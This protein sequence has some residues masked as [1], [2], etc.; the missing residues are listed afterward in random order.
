MIQRCNNPK[1]PDYKYYG[2]RGIIVCKRWRGENGFINFL[3][4]MGKSPSGKTLDRKNNNSG[5]FKK[6]CQWSTRKQQV[7]NMRSNRFYHFNNK[8]QILNDWA[9]EYHVKRQTLSRR[10]S[11]GMSIKEALLTPVRKYKK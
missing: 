9:K 7:R 1:C 4:D 11:K 10:L 6:N 8:D 5:Y 3:K 2:G